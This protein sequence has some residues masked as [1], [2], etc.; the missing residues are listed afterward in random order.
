MATPQPSTR[1]VQRVPNYHDFTSPDTKSGLPMKVEVT[2]RSAVARVTIPDHMAGW[3]AEGVTGAH[4]GAVAT[5][6]A[7]VMGQ[8]VSH[9]TKRAAWIKSISIEYFGLVPV[10][11]ALHCEASHFQKRGDREQVVDATITDDKGEVLARARGEYY[12]FEMGELRAP[13]ALLAASRLTCAQ[14][15]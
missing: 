13:H 3:R 6:L 5:V 14:A 11:L 12:L 4:P 8:G 15:F 10:G 2:A 7:T 1:E 9:R